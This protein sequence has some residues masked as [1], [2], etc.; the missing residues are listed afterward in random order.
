MNIL[1]Y[2]KKKLK[3]IFAVKKEKKG[4]ISTV[5]NMSGTSQSFVF[6]L[7][8]LEGR[9]QEISWTF[10]LDA[11]LN[12]ESKIWKI[13]AIPTG[14]IPPKDLADK[15]LS[16]AKKYDIP[17]EIDAIFLIEELKRK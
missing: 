10:G 9:P 3:D 7:P 17:L 6:D 11:E 8:Y 16:F 13:K 2:D 15:V 5:S 14:I 4:K 12:R 1:F